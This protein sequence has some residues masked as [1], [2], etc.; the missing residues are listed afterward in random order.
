M[1][2]II[3]GSRTI[4]DKEAVFIAIA[5]APWTP[6]S[7]ISG[8]A[9]GVDTLGEKWAHE[10]AV[11]VVRLE[12]DWNRFGK[13][14]GYL[15]NIEMAALAEALILIWDGKSKGS[16]HMKQIAESRGLKVFEVIIPG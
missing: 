14:A 16:G 2:T 3:A 1:R 4:V 10:H 12:A 15:R 9:A 7:V 6:T 5:R 11:K 8:G 13:R